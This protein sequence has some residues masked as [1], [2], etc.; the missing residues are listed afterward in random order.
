MPLCLWQS[1]NKPWVQFP[2]WCSIIN[3]PHV[4]L[5]LPI[6]FSWCEQPEFPLCFSLHH[7][8]HSQLLQHPLAA[9]SFSLTAWLLTHLSAFPAYIPAHPGIRVAIF[10][11]GVANN[12]SKIKTGQKFR[13]WLQKHAAFSNHGQWD[14]KADLLNQKDGGISP[15][16]VIEELMLSC[17]QTL[18][19]H[20][21][22][23]AMTWILSFPV[24]WNLGIPSSYLP[25]FSGFNSTSLAAA[26]GD[27][28]GVHCCS[29]RIFYLPSS[30]SC[31]VTLVFPPLFLSA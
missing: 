15:G 20:L 16:M 28:A 17:Q 4:I 19:P 5:L 8:P 6:S 31:S 27:A 24:P 14:F 23:T 3:S 29:H 21:C 9:H 11:P 18:F 10:I 7:H 1:Q 12:Q 25:S 26:G 22:P 2:P 13:R 30:S